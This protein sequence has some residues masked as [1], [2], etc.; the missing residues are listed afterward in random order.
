MVTVFFLESASELFFNFPWP[1]KSIMVV[2]PKIYKPAIMIYSGTLD[3]D[4]LDN[5]TTLAK[6]PLF[7]R[8]S[9]VFPC[10][11]HLD[12]VTTSLI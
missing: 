8:P 10:L 4:H 2:H 11:N 5:L 7:S 1:P 6:I 9:L 12:K 3:C